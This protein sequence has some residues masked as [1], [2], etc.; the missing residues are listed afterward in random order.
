MFYNPEE[1]RTLFS[2]D[3]R[4]DVF[5]VE[6]PA[7]WRSDGGES[8]SDT[9][10]HTH[11]PTEGP[12]EFATN[13]PPPWMDGWKYV[14]QPEMHGFNL[15]AAGF[16]SCQSACSLTSSFTLLLHVVDHWQPP[17]ESF[18]WRFNL[19]RHWWSTSVHFQ[20]L[21]PFLCWMCTF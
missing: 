1:G 6:P 11:A 5:I 3:G 17:E 20:R 2:L 14:I 12:F 13:T 15:E 7:E 8:P 19:S 9:H 18:T 10:T 4:M 21:H 16:I